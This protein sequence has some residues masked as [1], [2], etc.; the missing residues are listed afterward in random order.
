M[1][2]AKK[3]IINDKLS[4]FAKRTLVE[5][6][7][8]D[9]LWRNPELSLIQVRR[10]FS[11]AYQLLRPRNSESERMYSEALESATWKKGNR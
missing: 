9:I 7:I 8:R 1:S 5:Q 4:G 2:N 10:V 11:Y 6:L 3:I